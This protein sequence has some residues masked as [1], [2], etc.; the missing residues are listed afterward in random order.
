MASLARLPHLGTAAFSGDFN[1]PLKPLPKSK[2]IDSVY[3]ERPAK[4]KKLSKGQK[5]T[6]PAE[7]GSA[8]VYTDFGWDTMRTE[9]TSFT[10]PGPGMAEAELARPTSLARSSF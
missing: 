7:F 10:S 2:N 9:I 3:I 8:F 1:Q 5:Y 6:V 4:S